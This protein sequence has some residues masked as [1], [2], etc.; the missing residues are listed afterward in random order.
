MKSNKIEN[1]EFYEYNEGAA[2][3]EIIL[4]DASA[5]QMFLK[6][7]EIKKFENDDIT[8]LGEKIHVGCRSDLHGF[9][10]KPLEY[11]G[12]YEHYSVFYLGSDRD[13]FG[14]WYYYDLLHIVDDNMISLY[15]MPKCASQLIYNESKKEWI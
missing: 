9:Y 15:L 3:H 10:T 12:R 14:S 13:I 2:T 5:R 4:I 11:V 6:L 1:D 7:S 8:V